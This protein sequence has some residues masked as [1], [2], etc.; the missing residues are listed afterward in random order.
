LKRF[1]FF[2]VV[3]LILGFA[4][5]YLPIVLL[6]IYSFNA[7]RLVTVWGGFSTRWYGALLGNRALL[8]AAW[9][10]IRVALL[11]ASAATLLGTMAAV[12]L[13]RGGRFRGR[14]LF[15]GM[16]MHPSSC[17]R[18]SLACRYCSCSLRSASTAA[19]GR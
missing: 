3:A 18:S 7:S 5:L 15:S 4:F 11:S 9:V 13:T 8:D 12:A 6:V 2:N 17:R 16:I 1:S 10:T 19:S 14:T